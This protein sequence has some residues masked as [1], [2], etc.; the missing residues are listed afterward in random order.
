MAF[1]NGVRTTDSITEQTTTAGLDFSVVGLIGTAPIQNTDS[2]TKPINEPVL[3]TNLE[4]GVKTFGNASKGYTIPQ[5][6]EAI[7]ARVSSAK[8]VV[9]NVFDPDKHTAT[10]E[11]TEEETKTTTQP[12]PDAVTVADIIGGVKTD[13]TRYGLQAFKDAIAKCRFKPRIF[14][15]PKYSA[16]KSVETA[17]DTITDTFKG[18]AYA[19]LDATSAKDAITK[20]NDSNTSK[21]I[22]YVYPAVKVYN[23]YTQEEEIRPASAYA[24]ATRIYTDAVYGLHYSTGN[25]PVK[26]I[27]GTEIPIYFDIQ[28][29]NS[30]S[31]LLNSNGIT[32]IIYDE[33]YRFWGNRNAS[34]PDNENFDSFGN[35]VRVADYIDE[36]IAVK[37]R[38]FMSGPI[39]TGTIDDVVNFGKNFMANLKNKG[40][41][42]G[43]DC[44]FD[45][46]KN[47]YQSL[48][49]GKMTVTRKFLPPT[50]LEDLEYES[51]VDITLYSDIYND[52]D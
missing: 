32:T 11:D 12:S 20:R 35:I 41:L 45:E 19:D 49:A 29:E 30:D 34:Y 9:V 31:N 44:W 37:S 8:V 7:F 48:A 3:I 4:E 6:L 24:A 10:T 25:Q 15:A 33:G 23:A 43:Y 21:R 36:S 39:T 40:W 42:I 52:N 22:E 38:Q 26:G 28:D 1:I 17:L 47:D 50:P 46:K 18:Y 2:T 16:D 27:E 5:A 14:I 51:Q 13:G